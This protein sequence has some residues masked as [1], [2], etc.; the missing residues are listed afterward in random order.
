MF[1]FERFKPTVR[2]ALPLYAAENVRVLSVA[3][4]FARLVPSATP[5]MVE[6]ASEVF[7]IDAS[8]SVPVENEMP[9]AVVTETEPSCLAPS[10]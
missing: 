7:G 2:A 10:A 8:E 4:R 3:E 9:V 6:F 1:G 5:E